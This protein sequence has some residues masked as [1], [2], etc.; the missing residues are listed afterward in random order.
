M[1]KSR[2]LK[3]CVAIGVLALLLSQVDMNQLWQALTQLTP[4]LAA[5]LVFL[6]I[7]MLYISALK[8]KL[9]VESYGKEA[10]LWHLFKLYLLGYFINTLLPSYVG[11]DAVRSWYVGK[12]IGQHEAAAATILERYTGFVAMLSL[13]LVFMWFVDLVNWQMKFVVFLLCVGLATITAVT[14]SSSLLRQLGKIG[15]FEKLVKEL[16]KVQEALHLAKRNI[17][18]L[19]KTL[20]LSYFFHTL[21]VVNTLAAAAAVGWFDAPP[22]ELFVLLPLILLI[23]ALPIAPSGLGIQEG[24]FFFFLSSIGATPEQALGVGIVLRA[25]T[26]LLGLAGGLVWLTLRKEERNDGK[27]TI[28][29]K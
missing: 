23:G 21:T 24:A 16:F 12:K 14:L 19:L 11:G 1:L 15:I 5:Y 7:V 10:S 13:A 9:F 26:Y 18:L 6:S 4:A 2:S 20:S 27:G 25:K 8:W 28:R 29:K 22:W 3:I 17:P